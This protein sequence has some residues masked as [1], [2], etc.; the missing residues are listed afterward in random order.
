MFVSKL[1]PCTTTDLNSI[2]QT[3]EFRVQLLLLIV[4][5]MDRGFNRIGYNSTLDSPGLSLHVRNLIE[6]TKGQRI[7]ITWALY[8][9]CVSLGILHMHPIIM[10]PIHLTRAIH[11]DIP[12]KC[13]ERPCSWAQFNFLVFAYSAMRFYLGSEK[14]WF[15]TVHCAC[16]CFDEPLVCTNPAC[17]PSGSSILRPQVSECEGEKEPIK[18][19][20]QAIK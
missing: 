1:T 9:T 14:H 12:L 2:H 11:W 6:I 17:M 18:L 10:P 13:M 8:C 7:I 19:A 16:V 3:N 4:I 20:R 5:I 15:S